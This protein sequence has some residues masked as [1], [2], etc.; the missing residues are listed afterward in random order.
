MAVAAAP[1]VG[2]EPLLVVGGEDDPN[3][4]H[5]LATLEREGLCHRA[6]LIGPE[7]APALRW[8]LDGDELIL[9]GEPLRAAGAFLRH[10]VFGPM[11]QRDDAGRRRAAERALSWHLCLVGW[12]EVH[13]QVRLLNRRHLG[14]A[15]NK[16]AQLAVARRL[17]LKIPAT[18]IANQL[19]AL[20]DFLAGADKI[21]K[22]VAGG[23]LTRDYAE[24]RANIQHRPGFDGEPVA[25]SPAIV[26]QRLVAPEL[27]IY[28]V[29]DDLHA[30]VVDSP[31]LDYRERQDARLRPV[32]LDTLDSAL[33]AKLVALADGL[34]L[35]YAAADFKTDPQSG[36]L[37]FLEIN[38]A[39]MFAAFDRAA[40]GR[41][42]AS[43][44]AW[45]RRR[46]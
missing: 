46:P 8:D 15:N 21:A 25:A 42:C 41:L 29:G 40:E 13:E 44:I 26:Q 31:S 7:R 6:L 2:S 39:P 10:D 18:R 35:D 37:C 17:G 12:L 30:F 9:D 38:S 1:S 14:R 23:S 36:E 4:R 19:A 45:L 11:R 32:E 5:L 27:R 34:G 16:P 3:I 28:R 33:L 43:I 24:L 20:D 22:P